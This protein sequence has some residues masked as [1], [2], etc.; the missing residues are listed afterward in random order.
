MGA[1]GA[2]LGLSVREHH[3]VVQRVDT[4][5]LNRGFSQF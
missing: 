5:P 3:G 1:L 4:N 2:I